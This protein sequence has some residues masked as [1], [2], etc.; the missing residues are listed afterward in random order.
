[1]IQFSVRIPAT[2]EHLQEKCARQRNESRVIWRGPD[3]LRGKHYRIHDRDPLFRAEFLAVTPMTVERKQDKRVLCRNRI[4]FIG[5]PGQNAE[6][7]YTSNG[8]ACTRF[9]SIATSVSWKVKKPANTS[10][11]E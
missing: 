10:R 8:T 2:R 6:T 5:F 7:G 9:S 4:T 1:M 11:P 3:L